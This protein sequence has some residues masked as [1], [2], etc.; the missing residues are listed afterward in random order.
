[1]RVSACILCS[2]NASLLWHLIYYS[3][4]SN[5]FIKPPP[6]SYSVAYTIHS[7]SDSIVFMHSHTCKHDALIEYCV[8]T[9]STSITSGNLTCRHKNGNIFIAWGFV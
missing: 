5:V 3:H 8:V 1:M 7:R 9:Q 4:A 6:S 2:C